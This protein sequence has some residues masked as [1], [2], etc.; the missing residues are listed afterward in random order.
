MTHLGAVYA[1]E[2]LRNPKAPY[3]NL[4]EA[5]GR[6]SGHHR[7][8]VGLTPRPFT[9]WRKRPVRIMVMYTFIEA[10]YAVFAV[11]AVYAIQ[12]ARPTLSWH[13]HANV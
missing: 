3:M 6:P 12:L 8:V 13:K 10:V 2:T 11:Y 4:S 9:F 7:Q 1:E 5:C